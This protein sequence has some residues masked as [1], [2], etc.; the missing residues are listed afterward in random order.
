[1]TQAE[2]NNYALYKEAL[3]KAKAIRTLSEAQTLDT[4]SAFV[5]GGTDLRSKLESAEC[6]GGLEE[7]TGVIAQVNDWHHRIES[8][9]TPPRFE[10]Q[11]LARFNNEAKPPPNYPCAMKDFELWNRLASDLERLN[12][13]IKER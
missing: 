6:H 12:E 1:M 8:F 7:A 13:F 9:L 2:V 4:L 10:L 3:K 11:Y 5:L